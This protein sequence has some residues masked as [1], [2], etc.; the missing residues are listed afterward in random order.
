MNQV[1]NSQFVFGEDNDVF[2][3][4]NAL[5]SF[6]PATGQVNQIPGHGGEIIPGRLVDHLSAYAGELLR[7][8]QRRY[9]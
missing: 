1:S 9:S 5:L 2:G 3:V 6:E 7:R 8:L 4:W